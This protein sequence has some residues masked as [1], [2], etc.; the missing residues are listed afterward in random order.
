MFTYILI[1]L[2][3]QEKFE[4]TK[5]AIRIRKSK[6]NRQHN[7]QKKKYKGQTTI[8]SVTVV[9]LSAVDHEF[10]TRLILHKTLSIKEQNHKLIGSVS[11][12]L[13]SF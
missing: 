13:V 6:K 12:S 7:G 11:W 4:D 9:T 10:D 3:D 2:E 8:A 5:E 1:S